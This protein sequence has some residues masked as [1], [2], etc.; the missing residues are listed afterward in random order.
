MKRCKIC[1]FTMLA[2]ATMQVTAFATANPD[3]GDNSVIP[4]AIAIAV[5]A[6]LVLGLIMFLTRSKK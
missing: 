6:A 4:L 3:M 5:G 1:L 2:A